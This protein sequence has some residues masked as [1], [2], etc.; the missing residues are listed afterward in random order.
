MIST[1]QYHH[2][3]SL[4]LQY[5]RPRLC[6]L[7][8][9]PPSTATVFCELAA[10]I[11]FTREISTFQPKISPHLQWLQLSLS[12]TQIFYS[13]LERRCR[14]RK[15]QV[16]NQYNAKIL[17]LILLWLRERRPNRGSTHLLPSRSPSDDCPRLPGRDSLPPLDRTLMETTRDLHRITETGVLWE[18]SLY[19]RASC[20]FKL[21]ITTTKQRKFAQLM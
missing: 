7:S 15:Y 9:M 8:L 6:Y 2:S 4:G 21:V 16:Y 14:W 18:V 10:W 13:S 5:R 11:S 20:C 1:V 12:V 19:T 3:G 17:T